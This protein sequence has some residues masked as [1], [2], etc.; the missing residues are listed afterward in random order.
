MATVLVVD[1][2]AMACQLASVVLQHAGHRVLAAAGGAEG[3]QVALA[4]RPDVIL[5]DMHMPQ[6]DGFEFLRRLKAEPQGRGI[7][8][9]AVTGMAMQGDHE[10][11]LAA[12][13]DAYLAKP[14]AYRTMLSLVAG[15]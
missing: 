14:Y 7:K 10:A 4:E 8:V 5:L 9:L 12:G 13:C 1:D 11:I 3:L 15:L 6:M 2:D